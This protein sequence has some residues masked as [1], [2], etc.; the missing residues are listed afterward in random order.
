M[1]KRTLLRKIDF[2][3]IIQDWMERGPM[4]SKVLAILA[5]QLYEQAEADTLTKN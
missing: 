3:I 2:L 4:N 5:K 1:G